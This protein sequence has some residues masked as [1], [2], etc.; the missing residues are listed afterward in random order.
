M[1]A[2]V[3]AAARDAVA[4]AD[5]TELVRQILAILAAQ[6]ATRQQSA[7]QQAAPV[8]QFDT[9]K[10][11]VGGGVVVAGA[12]AGAVFALALAMFAVAIAVGAACATGCFVILRKLI[13]D[14]K[15]GN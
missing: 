8:K 12:S 2:P 9:K 15:A 13:A 1:E 6:Q 5:N 10:W 14:M 7:V 4:A 3:S 11:L